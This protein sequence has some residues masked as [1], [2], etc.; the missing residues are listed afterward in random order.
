[1]FYKTMPICVTR[2]MLLCWNNPSLKG[3]MLHNEGK[4]Q[5]IV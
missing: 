5:Q 3:Q 2:F 1:M 4:I